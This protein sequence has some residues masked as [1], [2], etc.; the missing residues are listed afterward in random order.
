MD[1]SRLKKVGFWTMIIGTSLF[2]WFL[3]FFGLFYVSY[4]INE[5]VG[6]PSGWC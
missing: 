2:I 3:L 6:I 4:L 5:I 1:K